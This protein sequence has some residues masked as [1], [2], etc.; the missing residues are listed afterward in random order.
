M[1]NLAIPVI[2]G[3]FDPTNMV[4]TESGYLQFPAGTT[5]QWSEPQGTSFIHSAK[6]V[7]SLREECFRSMNLQ[8]QGRSMRATPAM[9][10]GRSKQLEMAPAKQILAGMGDDLRRHMQ[11][12][13]ADVKDVRRDDV[14]PDV[15]GFTFEDDM[16]T[17]EVFAVTSVM[18][19]KIPSENFE[20]YMYKKVA[21][22]WMVDA[23]R[24]EL[25]KV[26]DQI[27]KGPTMKER[28]EEELSTRI[29]LV[30]GE[31]KANLKKA[32]GGPTMPPG[33]GGAGPSPAPAVK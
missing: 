32:P 25:V 29:K 2:I 13:L 4:S 24:E 20:K 11:A 33:R 7:E 19:L 12:V 27:D 9:Q 31:M 22:A 6:R 16:T 1:S 15:R 3:D 28:E 21:K 26:Y 10:S 14:N 17:E 30:Q 5:Y 8:A 23:N 18:S